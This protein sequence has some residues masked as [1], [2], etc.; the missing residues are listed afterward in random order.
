VHTGQRPGANTTTYEL[1]QRRHCSEL[2]R[3][4]K[5]EENSLFSKHARLLAL[6]VI[7]DRRI[8]SLSQSYDCELQCQRCKN[9]QRHELP[10]AL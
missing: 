3:F 8:G 7:H 9:L 5:V 10:S 4:F 2:E 6:Y 1:I